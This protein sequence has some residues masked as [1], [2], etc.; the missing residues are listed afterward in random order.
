MKTKTIIITIIL[1]FFLHPYDTTGGTAAD[2]GD[3][4]L[5]IIKTAEK[6]LGARY[7]Y[8]GMTTNGFDCSGFVQFVFRENGITLPRST[9]DQ[10]E[11]GKKIE[12]SNAKPG[13][14]VFFNIYGARISH[15]G[16]F[17]GKTVFIH[18]PTWGKRVSYADMNLPY[19]KRTFVGAVTYLDP[20]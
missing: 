7:N 6:Y 9:V 14:L 3:K 2:Y 13:D 18:A 11:R 12:L 15:V 20:D 4:R 19:W 8:G 16:I 1:S 17:A 5:L 10:F